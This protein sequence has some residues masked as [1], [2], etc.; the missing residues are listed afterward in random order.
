MI[1]LEN[2]MVHQLLSYVP[3]ASEPLSFD[4]ISWHVWLESFVLIYLFIYLLF[5]LNFGG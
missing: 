4:R 3:D 1:L 2:E 5:F